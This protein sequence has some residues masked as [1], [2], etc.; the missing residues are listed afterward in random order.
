MNHSYLPPIPPIGESARA[1]A[2]AHQNDLTKPP[3]SLG[4][5][6]ELAVFYAGARAAFPVATP[7]KAFLPVFGADHGV[8]A[9]NVSAFP[10]SLTTPI[11]QNVVNGGAGICVLARQFN[12]ELLA[13]DVGL[14]ADL[15]ES[16]KSRVPVLNHKIRR[17]T[18]NLRV[19]DAMT[20]AEAEAALS[21]GVRIALER[22]RDGVEVVGVGEVG[23]G[24]TT[25]SAALIAA[26]TKQSPSI[27]TGR[28]TGIDDAGLASKIRV[29]DEALLRVGSRT[30]PFDIARALGGLEILSMAGFM[31]G[32]ASQRMP[33]VIDGLIASAAALV[34]AALRPGVERY[35]VAS[36][37]STEPGIVAAL[38]HLKLRPLVELE[39]RLG[40]GTGSVLGIAL[41]RAS[42]AISNEMATFASAGLV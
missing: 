2:L 13:V 32:S 38:S 4:R 42:V 20:E 15:V 14:T 24:N 37:R 34:A 25:P 28:G 12:V 16:P 40:E 29:I 26:F 21:L 11:M 19:E 22:A 23:I 30:N 41:L 31:I 17:G 8:A 27:V 9:E 5:L 7:T 35:F 1:K 3:G 36:H 39:M 10:P 18:R 6:E 33:V